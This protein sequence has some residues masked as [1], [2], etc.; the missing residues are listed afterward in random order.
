MFETHISI[1]VELSISLVLSLLILL[2]FARK[3]TNIIIFITSLICWFMNLY[4][5]ILIPYDVY[6]TQ[7]DKGN[8]PETTKKFIQIGYKISYWVL[9]VLSW[10]VIPIM[11]GYET[12]GEITISKKLKASLI[13]N[14][15]FF[16]ILGILGL[17][18]IIF[19]IAKYGLSYTFLFVKNFSLIYGLLFYFFLLS[20]GLVKLP[21]TLYLKFKYDNHIKYLEW[22]INNFKT[23]LGTISHDLFIYFS[24]IK[25]TL[26]T[27]GGNELNNE[28]LDEKDDLDNEEEI[29]V[30]ENL[31]NKKKS[32]NINEKPDGFEEIE[33]YLDY[34]KKKLSEFEEDG[35]KYGI[36]M[37]KEKF[38]DKAAISKCKDFIK[39][40]SKINSNEIDS[41]RLQCRLANSYKRWAILNSINYLNQKKFDGDDDNK[42]E[43][44]INEINTD[45]SYDSNK[46]N[47]NKNE[48]ENKIEQTLEEE[49]FI[50]LD[51]FTGCK[52]MYYSAIKKYFYIVILI[53]SI[54]AG[55]IIIACELCIV[56]GFTFITIFK[57]MESI[58]AIHFAIL[59]PL[60]YLISM[61]NYTLFKMKLT[62]IL[63][64]YGP[65]QT[66]SV[67]LITFSSYLSR[68]YFAI[69][70]NFMQ[71]INQFSKYQYRTNFEYF[72]GL[73]NYNFILYFIRFFPIIFFI[74]IILFIFNVPGKILSCCCGYNMF[75]FETEKRNEGIKK[76][77]EYLMKINKKLDGKKLVHTDFIIFDYM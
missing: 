76:G 56:C 24:R 42:I 35:I 18:A 77:H 54:L 15:K 5:I 14:V 12:S 34:M 49:G 46:K 22:K 71:A 59:I 45:S 11:K 38:E 68:L 55:V 58:V 65:R 31:I 13:S 72:F 41:L 7:S 52:L 17:F 47:K 43:D 74:L 36:D 26:D 29:K 19:C 28:A 62:R 16:A 8:I 64:M 67:S 6:Y 2:Y 40:N 44:D 48:E 53:L 39:I 75:E 3:N 69:C 32:K 60:I 61:T 30:K 27:F 51:N 50:P 9:F 1:I 37:K 20:Y 33:D 4:L 73:N 21:K 25:A 10:L 63:Y 57:K 70:L 66:D 23:K